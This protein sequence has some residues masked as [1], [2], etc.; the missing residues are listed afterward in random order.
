MQHVDKCSMAPVQ[1][2]TEKGCTVSES[3][4]PFCINAR[5]SITCLS[6]QLNLQLIGQL[7]KN[8][9]NKHQLIDC[10]KSLI[11]H[12]ESIYP[13]SQITV[14]YTPAHIIQKTGDL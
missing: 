2:Q 12:K 11:R 3:G 7:D 14:D 6:N 1:K 4:Q 9:L 8:T 10:L 13:P 5:L